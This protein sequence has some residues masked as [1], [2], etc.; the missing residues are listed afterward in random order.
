ME[1]LKFKY[2]LAKKLC[3]KDFKLLA[4]SLNKIVNSVYDILYQSNGVLNCDYKS[5]HS[6]YVYNYVMSD[7]ED[8][9]L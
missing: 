4:G 9:T 3:G 5:K 1:K 8:I 7:D 6:Q 2:L